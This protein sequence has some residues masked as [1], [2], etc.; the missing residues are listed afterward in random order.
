MASKKRKSHTR[1]QAAA[2][3]NL[4]TLPGGGLDSSRL[5]QWYVSSLHADWIQDFDM[6]VS[7]LAADH[8]AISIRIVT[9]R[10]VMHICK[11]RRVYPVPGC[12]HEPA[13]GK[14]YCHC[15]RT[16]ICRQYYPVPTS[17]YRTP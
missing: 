11:P 5:D 17:D 7:G 15:A 3:T 13:N 4:Y 1:F 8:N 6:S 2:Y 12:A 14:S 10:T 9:S 16:A